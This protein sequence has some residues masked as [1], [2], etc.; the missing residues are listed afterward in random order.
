MIQLNLLPDLKK[1]FIQ[2]QKTK[3]MVISVSLITAVSAIALSILMFIYVNF[4]QAL[5]I[6][7]ATDDIKSKNQQLND[8]TELPK[9]LT[10]QNQLAALP[11]LRDGQG[12]TSRI[13]DFL[14]VLNPSPPNNVSLAV[15][16]VGTID[17]SI[18]LNGTTR[19]FEALNVFV[20]TLKN[21]EITYRLE[22]S[23]ESVT[24]NMLDKVLVQS[25]G[26]SKINNRVVVSFS[27][28]A[29]YKPEM[30]NISSLDTKA[31]VPNITTTKS[32]TQSPNSDIF[33][34]GGD[35]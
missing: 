19:N 6:N 16:Q 29:N 3:S 18:I 31:S 14:N 20:D 26:L 24:T 9:H 11:T 8:M 5:Q 27:I 34:N 15:L 17:N 33:D 28:K 10:I 1:E 35:E 21:A 4:V 2:V 32:V 23:Q 7:L 30:T 12:V 13:L 22:N 25:S